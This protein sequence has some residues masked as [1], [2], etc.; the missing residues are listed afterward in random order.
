MLNVVTVTV[1]TFLSQ[2]FSKARRRVVQPHVPSSAACSEQGPLPQPA[3]H[4]KAYPAAKER[5]KNV[6][7]TTLQFSFQPLPQAD[8]DVAA[9]PPWL[10]VLPWSGLLLPGE[11]VDIGATVH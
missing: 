1:P 9:W 8:G 6:G 7:Q 10:S 4:S 5:V 3:W 11:T 2:P